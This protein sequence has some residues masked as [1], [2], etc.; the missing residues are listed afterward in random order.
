MTRDEGQP[1]AGWFKDPEG[2]GLRY[3]D[4]RGW[5]EHR[6]IEPVGAA[7]RPQVAARQGPSRRA[8]SAATPLDRFKQLP[9]SDRAALLIA[10]AAIVG[11][12]IGI[13]SP[14]AQALFVSKNGIESDGAPVL[15]CALI[16]AGLLWLYLG[17]P[18]AVPA[19]IAALL[20]LAGAAT[21]VIGLVR[22]NN[23]EIVLIGVNVADPASGVYV[24]IA[25]SAVL[26]LSAG[27]LALRG[28]RG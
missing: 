20:G 10:L 25:S 23:Q 12:V 8:Q 16:A 26:A 19:L 6:H 2:P 21:G 13:F 24:T 14:W 18:R 22:I 11:M 28:R 1:A 5:T 4:G 7:L 17:R 27:Y 3:W 9:A 15:P